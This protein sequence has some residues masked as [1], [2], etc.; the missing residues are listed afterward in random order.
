MAF[1]KFNDWLLLREEAPQMRQSGPSSSTEQEIKKVTASLVGQPKA[2]R[3][4]A[5]KQLAAKAASNPT[6]KP[7]DIAAIAAAAE[8]DS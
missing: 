2:K 3:Q 7:K 4:S 8:E 1:I 5:L 6:S